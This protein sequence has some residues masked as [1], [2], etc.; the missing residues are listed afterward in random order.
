MQCT[1]KEWKRWLYNGVIEP[2]T[3]LNFVNV[4]GPM[5]CRS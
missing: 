2:I 3:V 5:F 4:E 1:R